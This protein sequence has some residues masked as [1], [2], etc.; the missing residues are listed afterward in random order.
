MTGLPAHLLMTMSES[1]RLQPA[2]SSA[3]LQMFDVAVRNGEMS[4]PSSSPRAP[5]QQPE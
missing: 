2:V 3:W 4:D 1:C 5:Q